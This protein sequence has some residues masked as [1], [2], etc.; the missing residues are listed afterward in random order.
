MEN[1]YYFLE[2]ETVELS[3]VVIL[4]LPAAARRPQN[5]SVIELS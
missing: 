2:K 1:A 5:P 4:S 3:W